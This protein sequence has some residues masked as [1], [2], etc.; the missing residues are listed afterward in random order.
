MPIARPP[1]DVGVRTNRRSANYYRT[2]NASVDNL[3]TTWIDE[4]SDRP[5]YEKGAVIKLPMGDTF[6][7]TT[8]YE[9]LNWTVGSAN[10]AT[11]KFRLGNLN[12][13]IRDTGYDGILILAGYPRVYREIP[14]DASNE[15][16][17]KALN[18]IASQKVN[19]GENLATLGQ[20]ARLLSLRT[21]NLTDVLAAFY[22][23]ARGKD[24]KV[25]RSFANRNAR[26]LG[27]DGVP[28]RL[29]RLYIEYVYGLKPLMQDVY[30]AYQMMQDAA[31]KTPLLKASAKAARQGSLPRSFASGTRGD[32]TKDGFTANITVGTT[33]WARLDEKWSGLVALNQLG[34]MNPAAL[35]WELVPWSFV[36]DWVLPIGPVL[37]AFSAR[38]G[39][40]F[41][42]G[43]L[44]MRQSESHVATYSIDCGVANSYALKT[45]SAYPVR[46]E[47][48]IRHRLL[49][50]PLPGLWVDSDPLR[51][52]RIFKATA[53]ALLNLGKARRDISKYGD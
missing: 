2:R 32:V 1:G 36:V 43:S 8:H 14:K 44:S 4:Y 33:I 49:D 27:R 45:D 22:K 46:F 50:W 41:V 25:W 5:T 31:T 37:N 21:R 18:K 9:V 35:I 29:A 24:W 10:P 19:L 40:K 20:T 6:R 53:L 16:F 26:D 12:Y 23:S 3:T 15:V 7:R 38:A 34:L 28:E 48:Y 11:A 39:L 47:R 51:G 13:D 17:T 52:D 42:D 30:S